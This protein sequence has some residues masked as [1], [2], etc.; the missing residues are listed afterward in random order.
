[1]Q[2][3]NNNFEGLFKVMK[4]VSEKNLDRFKLKELLE[5]IYHD[6]NS[7]DIELVFS[8]LLKILDD[9]QINSGSSQ[10]K[11]IIPWN[12]THS[13][14]IT[15][16][17]S[18]SRDGESSLV[19]LK[20][21]LERYFQELSEIVH[22]LP[23]LK[24]TSDGG[25]AVSSHKLLDERFG[26]WD[27]LKRLSKKHILMADLVLNHVSSSH[28]WVQQF[29]KGQE[30]GLSNILVPSKDS[31][32]NN[33]IRPRNSS[34]FS[35]INTNEGP[36]QVWT[37][38]GSD[39][40]D[41]NWQNP[42]IF[43]EF[44]NLIIDYVNSGVKWFRLDAVGFIWKES[45]TTCLHLPQAHLIVKAL[46]I[47][48]STLLREG[49]LITETNV[50]QKENLSYLESE[51]EAHMAYNFPLPPLLLEA[52]MTSRADILNSWIYDWPKLPINTTLFNFTASHDG[53]GLRPLE[54][55]MSDGRIKE[56]LINCEKRGGLVSHRRLSNGEDKPYE[57]NISWWS[58]M[59]DSSRDKERFQQSRFILSQLLVMALKGVPAFYLPAL[60]AS[61]N[62]IKRFS[63]TGERRDLNREKFDY[64]MLLTQLND[65]NSNARRNLTILSNAMKIRS[66]L[67]PFHPSSDMK[68]LT[69]DR[70]DVV[71]IQ[72]SSGD[73]SIF[74]IHN[75]TEN[76]INYSINKDFIN[77]SLNKEILLKDYLCG[78]EYNNLNIV[79]EP[80]QV[81]WIGYK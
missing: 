5:L 43:L 75:I 76:K 13:V 74:A 50:P 77:P 31:D 2:N 45:G 1:M 67:K 24:S 34:L 60:L 48:L 17:D 56:L 16:A 65:F 33:V 41:L 61:N 59:E 38:F 6:H 39:Q 27:D 58:A 40:I 52:V 80:F 73:N 68:C 26:N 18:V 14:L 15:Y 70:P 53:V 79:L 69:K 21:I 12:Q 10:L 19:T 46:R 81:V 29:I 42:K 7:E 54:G 20:L 35:Q 55:L 49:V 4:N 37:T 62:D 66:E 51:D 36:K 22:I 71:T 44:L 47:K 72:R 30:P 78:K 57:L 64:E 25:F 3:N 63:I 28:P 11:E 8:K 23:F 32:W 9:F